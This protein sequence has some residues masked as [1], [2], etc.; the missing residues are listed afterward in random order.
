MLLRNMNDLFGSYTQRHWGCGWLLCGC[1]TLLVVMNACSTNG[2]VHKQI[3]SYT[4]PSPPVLIYVRSVS[5]DRTVVEYDVKSNREFPIFFLWSEPIC[6]EHG[7]TYLSHRDWT[8]RRYSHSLRF[9]GVKLYDL[10]IL[11]VIELQPGASLYL[12]LEYR[13]PF[14]PNCNIE[15]AVAEGLSEQDRATIL[16]IDDNSYGELFDWIIGKTDVIRISLPV[17]PQKPTRYLPFHSH[18]NDCAL[19]DGKNIPFL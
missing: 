11:Y 16:T 2:R 18:Q 19:T 1:A 17:H 4:E 10:P 7:K 15:F 9:Y 13:T 12:A 14:E 6:V 5:K 3:A 8:C